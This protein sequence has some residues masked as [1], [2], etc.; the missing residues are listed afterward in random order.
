MGSG[1][2]GQLGNGESCDESLPFKIPISKK[3]ADIATGRFHSCV[4]AEDGTVYTFG[5]SHYGQC[6]HA[7]LDNEYTPRPV[8][9]FT[10]NAI[11]AVAASCGENHTVIL[12]G[13]HSLSIQLKF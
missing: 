5:G 12:S 6:G 4:V 10:S 2:E 8:E 11:H 3:I 9:F 13:T 7:C 1:L